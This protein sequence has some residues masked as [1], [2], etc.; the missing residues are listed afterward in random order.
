MISVFNGC[1]YSFLISSSFFIFCDLNRR[2]SCYL[3]YFRSYYLKSF[4]LKNLRWKQVHCSSSKEY[5]NSDLN[6]LKKDCCM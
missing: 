5:C 6:F 3:N 4:H 2:R 1:L